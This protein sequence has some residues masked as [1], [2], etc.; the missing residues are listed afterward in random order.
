MSLVINKNLYWQNKNLKECKWG[1]KRMWES[2]WMRKNIR[3]RESTKSPKHLPWSATCSCE[4]GGEGGWCTWWWW[5]CV[6]V[7]DSSDDARTTTGPPTTSRPSKSRLREATQT[8]IRGVREWVV[9]EEGEGCSDLYNWCLFFLTSW[10]LVNKYCPL[11]IFL[12]NNTY[13]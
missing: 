1:R 6:V 7:S 11:N 13:Q 10:Y 8:G 12:V 2:V 9:G 5:W 4:R 3:I